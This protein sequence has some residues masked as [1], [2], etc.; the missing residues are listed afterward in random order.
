LEKAK[1]PEELRRSMAGWID[2]RTGVIRDLLF[3]APEAAAP[4]LPITCAAVL[5]SYTEGAYV[6]RE[7]ENTSGKGLTHV[8]AM[9][10]AVGEAIE[11]YSAA[12]C[13]PADLHRAA[14]DELRGDVLDPRLFCLYEDAQ[15]DSP[16]FP[17]ARFDSGR[18][19]AWTRGCWL[20][21]GL[22][23][24]VPALL[25]YR[26]LRV[27]HEENFCQATSNGLAAGADFD[28]AS[29]R[30]VLE[31]VERDALMVTWLARRGGR[32]LLVDGAL[33]AGTREALRQL[34]ERRVE[35]EIILLDV[36]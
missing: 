9:I 31:L 10:G 15:Y 1:D 18:P 3:P 11:R 14:R 34:R 28:D 20:D 5:S 19:M 17:F 16:G 4:E 33:N 30:A 32:R 8:E 12:R 35:V 23:V 36:G 7:M 29:M 27:R 13:R 26:N 24:W 21:T 2:S 6:P 25:T 22:P